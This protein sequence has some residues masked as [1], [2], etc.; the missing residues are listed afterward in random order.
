M[1]EKKLF[2]H[3]RAGD[4]MLAN[5]L[6]YRISFFQVPSNK[7]VSFKSMLTNYSDNFSSR[8]DRKEVYGRMDPIQ[9]FQG[10]T[11]SIN[12]AWDVVSAD[13]Y[14]ARENLRKISMLMN[15]LYPSYESDGDRAGLI[16]T[17]PVFKV[18]FLNLITNT[19]QSK[20]GAG[21]DAK[22]AGLA[23]TIDGFQFAPVL[24]Y[25]FHG[26]P[27]DLNQKVESTLKNMSS[28]AQ[29]DNLS[30]YPKVINMSCV[31]H[32]SHQHQLGWTTT[33]KP[34][35]AG[36]PYDVRINE[37]IPEGGSRQQRQRRQLW[38]EGENSF[39]EPDSIVNNAANANVTPDGHRGSLGQNLVA[40]EGAGA[41]DHRL[42]QKQV[43][44][45][46]GEGA[47]DADENRFKGLSN[48]GNS[49]LTKL[50]AGIHEEVRGQHT[51]PKEEVQLTP[52]RNR[53]LRD[54]AQKGPEFNEGIP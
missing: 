3:G 25:G 22:T 30:I 38:V 28:T 11:R 12:V 49:D 32:V 54:R 13:A 2:R 7:E 18:K 33:S 15:M 45:L 40:P 42:M 35:S 51:R 46:T 34:R 10:T 8:W 39:E 48:K 21:S 41:S 50:I 29:L 24:E 16:N 47:L 26:H 14:E 44:E 23:G 1:S 19:G 5:K 17:A 36:F 6:N 31:I 52:E 9:V 27:P 43:E 4:M 20:G 53:A 37:I